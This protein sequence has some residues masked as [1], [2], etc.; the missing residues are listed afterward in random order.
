[1]VCVNSTQLFLKNYFLHLLKSVFVTLTQV[2][3]PT[4]TP[5]SKELP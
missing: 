4:R 3:L 1:M 5:D 2:T